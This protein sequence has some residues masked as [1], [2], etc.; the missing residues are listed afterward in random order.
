MQVRLSSKLAVSGVA[1]LVLCGLGGPAAAKRPVATGNKH[2][3]GAQ[4]RP[5]DMKQE[6]PGELYASSWQR[7][8][9]RS[10]GQDDL[11]VRFSSMTGAPRVIYGDLGQAPEAAKSEDRAMLFLQTHAETLGV[12]VR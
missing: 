12:D 8:S 2:A 4:L 6:M 1:A 10:S 7:F 5:I 11:F 3:M 9:K